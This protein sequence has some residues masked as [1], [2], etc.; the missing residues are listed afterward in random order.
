MEKMLSPP[1]RRMCAARPRPRT[2][3]LAI[4]ATLATYMLVF[5]GPSKRFQVV[6]Y[7]HDSS[8]ASISGPASLD[9]N[10]VKTTWDFSIEDIKGWHDPDDNEDPNDVEPGYDTDG[11]VREPGQISKTQLEK[12]LRTMWRYAYKMSAK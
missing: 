5:N 10:R 11:T 9:S 12:D 2:I 7:L 3:V 1:S 4:V 6:P 8:G